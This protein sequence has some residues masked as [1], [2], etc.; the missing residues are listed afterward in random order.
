MQNQYEQRGV[1]LLEIIVSIAV[2]AALLLAAMQRVMVWQSTANINLA[3]VQ[4]NVV[5]LLAAASAKYYETC[6]PTTGPVPTQALSCAD[7]GLNTA[8]CVNQWGTNTASDFSVQLVQQAGTSVYKLIVSGNFSNYPSTKLSALAKVLNADGNIQGS[9]LTWT[10]LPSNSSI[11][12][13]VWYRTP[14]NYLAATNTTET[15]G[16]RVGSSMWMMDADLAE[17]GK[18]QPT[19]TTGSPCAD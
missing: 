10:R 8:R 18:S 5:E 6:R 1:S 14:G 2:I 9:T 16:L 11:N 3:Q 7:L 4:E 19:I 15:G 13:G 17:F 12:P